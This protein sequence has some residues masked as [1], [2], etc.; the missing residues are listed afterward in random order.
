MAFVENDNLIK[1]ISVLKVLKKNGDLDEDKYFLYQDFKWRNILEYSVLESWMK[2][3][4]QS[5]SI[6]N[7]FYL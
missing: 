4:C 5:V 6:V 2:H 7:Y 1:V 3:H